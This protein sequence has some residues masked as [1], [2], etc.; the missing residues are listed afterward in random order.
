MSVTSRPTSPNAR[1]RSPVKRTTLLLLLGAAAF[2]Q[3]T[4]TDAAETS[5]PKPNIVFIL[6]DD[7]GYSD[8]GCYGGEIAT[9][10]LDALAKDGLRFTQ[11]YNTARCWPTRN[12]LLSGYYAQSTKS[13][14]AYKAGGR[15]SRPRWVGLLPEL[16]KPA[17]YRSYHSGKWHL[18]GPVLPT[19]FEH[20]YALEDHNHFFTPQKHLVDDKPLPP[21]P[22]DQPKYVTTT[23]ADY[24]IEH[25]QQ[26]AAEHAGKPFFSYVAFTSPHF[27]LH[28]PA[29]DVAR[30]RD[31][32]KQGWEKIRTARYERMKGKGLVS[33]ELSQPERDLGPPYPFPDA[34]KILGPGEV[35]L[36]LPWDSLT[37][38]Q[39]EFQAA[40]M[41]VHAAMVDVMDR[42]IGRIIAQ[43]KAMNAFEDTLILFASDNGASA[44]IMVRGSGH[45]PQA[46]PG[47]EATYLCL[48]PG[49]STVANTPHRRHKTWVHE[50]GVSTPLV[51]HW[52]KGIAARGELRSDVGH[53]VD[54]VPT[55]LELAGVTLPKDREGF[56]VPP[57]QGRSFAAA[58]TGKAAGE[59]DYVWW[60]HEDN[61]AIRAGDW[62]LVAAKGDPWELYDL[63]SDRSESHNLAA[64]NPDK[65]RELETLWQKQHDEYLALSLTAPSPEMPKRPGAGK[66][67]AAGGKKKSAAATND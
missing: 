36:P 23:I 31:L 45:D 2:V 17:G 11:F 26:H 43:L 4:R 57:L 10:N 12:A 51:A 53:V 61:R 40:K 66:K 27:P 3:A 39:Q 18:V 9:P 44:E 7:L 1:L 65:V 59:R 42:E 67:A 60:L 48:G 58:L 35:N 52:P 13:D 49:W 32:Y 24:A 56:A 21:T 46:A 34:M 38:E 37:A 20:S 16:L 30:Y 28:A 22:A 14:T 62:K 29:E 5:P 33:C 47:S 63:S 50:G 25:L 15:G 54:F 64:A 41:A 55:A 6:A 8:L 19:G